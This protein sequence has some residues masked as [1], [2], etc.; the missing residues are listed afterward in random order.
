MIIGGSI[1]LEKQQQLSPSWKSGKKHSALEFYIKEIDPEQEMSRTSFTNRAIVAGENV[2]EE[3]KTVRDELAKLKIPQGI[4]T[5][6]AMQINV[7]EANRPL[8]DKIKADM[9][10]SLGLNVVQ[11]QYMMQLLWMNYLLYLQQK[12]QQVGIKKDA[13]DLSGPD[14]VKRLVQI[15]LLDRESD[16]PIIERIKSN[17][18]E[19]E[20]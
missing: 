15:L 13:S 16:A 14:M 12:V 20:G 3:W 7:E 2:Q 11:T 9:A 19:W 6:T 1:K 18:K 17:L 4:S 10:C 5:P 8:F